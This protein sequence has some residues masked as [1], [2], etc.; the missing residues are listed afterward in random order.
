MNKLTKYAS[1]YVKLDLMKARLEFF[2]NDSGTKGV[3]LIIKTK[4][5]SYHE[6]SIQALN[7]EGS[8]RS[9]KIPKSNWD[10][11]LRDNLWVALV[12]FMKDMEPA[13][14]LIPSIIWENPNQIF[15][16][17]DQGERHKHLSNWEIKLFTK[18]I[19]ELR[20]Y[21]FHDMVQ[22]LQ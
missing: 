5:G 7:L 4:Q 9:I 8:E 3:D 22:E 6:I 10:Y 13:F 11:E 21:G 17:N 15:I 12:L 18:A 19:Q 20:K 2:S 14:Y 16:D 1:H